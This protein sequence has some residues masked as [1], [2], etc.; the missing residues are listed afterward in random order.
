M[1]RKILIAAAFAAM[2][3]SC[4]YESRN[5]EVVDVILETDMG[6]DI[7]DALT[8]ALAYNYVESGKMNLL[9]V[10]LNKDGY[11]PAEFV[12]IMNT[13]YGHPEVPIGII[14]GG[15]ECDGAVNYARIVSEMKTGDGTPLFS[16]TIPDCNELP[17]AHNLYRRILS[18][19]PDNSVVIVSVGFSTNLIKLL[20]TRAD[21]YSDLNGRDLVAR[22]VR[23]LVVMAGNF[24]D[25]GFYEYNV[26]M[27][28]PS[29]K[30]IFE[31]WPT[32][33]VASPFELGIQTCYPA[34]SIEN[35]F[36]WS[37]QNP[38]VEAYKSY[39]QMPYDRPMW[40][41]TALLYAVE[42]ETWFTMSESGKIRVTDEGATIFMSDPQGN[43]R[44]M[45]VNPDQA[46]RI[47]GHV[48]G[49]IP[50]VPASRQ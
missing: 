34:T 10:C 45:K 13:F 11:G 44:Y 29:A 38:L 41:P 26:K 43:R 27:D 1:F 31:T 47:V 40:D 20:E 39:L 19:R 32:P 14:R 12:D 3:L 35:D 24:E 16:R 5:E 17:E 6:N 21:E 36:L 37:S 22:K 49:L 8:L 46:G 9:A 30:I 25:P 50:F 48:V 42:G 15:A 28:V 18:S 33:L 2:A 23:K 7:D 4:G